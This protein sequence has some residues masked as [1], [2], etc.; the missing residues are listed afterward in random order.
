MLTESKTMT[1]TVF[2]LLFI[3]FGLNTNAQNY[4]LLKKKDSHIRLK[5]YEGETLRFKHKDSTHM[6]REELQLIT[7]SSVF[8]KS[9]ETMIEDIRIIQYRNSRF[10]I[11]F[12]RSLGRSLVYGGPMFFGINGFNTLLFSW[13][14]SW[15]WAATV[16]ATMSAIGLVIQG[17]L[18]LTAERRIKFGKRWE[19]VPYDFK[20]MFSPPKTP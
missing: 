7:D 10:S 19:L 5:I 14:P 6:Q 11:V 8:T 3:C 9:G 13:A 16:G 17:T 20:N 12:L 1:K 15:A 2:L 4:L 18:K